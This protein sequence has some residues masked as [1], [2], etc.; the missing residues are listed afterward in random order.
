LL[1]ICGGSRGSPAYVLGVGY[2]LSPGAVDSLSLGDSASKSIVVSYAEW[3]DFYVKGISSGWMSDA[4]WSGQ[5]LTLTLNGSSGSTGILT[6]YCGSRGLPNAITGLTGTEYS[7]FTKILFGTYQFAS[8]LTVTLD[9]TVSVTGP[10]GGGGGGGPSVVRFV[11]STLRLSVPQGQTVSGLLTFNWTGVND[12]TITNVRF[13]NSPDWLVV[14]E[15]LPKTVTK[16]MSDMSGTG[17]VAVRITVPS[18]AQPGDY[19]VVAEV[20]ATGPGGSVASSG[21]VNFTVVQP[22]ILSS[23]VSDLMA[24]LFVLILGIFVAYT[25]FFRR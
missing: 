21:Y 13:Q 19:S 20:D 2:E 15:S 23:P 11:V 1:Q 10:G 17:S 14:A 22:S 5:K 18:D 4:S 24:F 25:Y 7:A 9:W 6:V 3:G 12:L 8:P 16:Q